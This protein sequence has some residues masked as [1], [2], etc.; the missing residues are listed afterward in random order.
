MNV[1]N[2]MLVEDDTFFAETFM[3]RLK[4]FGDYQIHHF[5]SVER[6]LANLTAVDPEIVFLDHILGGVN[7]VDALPIFKERK[8]GCEIV[9][10]SS[11]RDVKVLAKALQD[12]ASKYF[13]KDA[14]LMHNAGDVIQEVE[15]RPTGFRAFW[16]NFIADFKLLSL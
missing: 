16:Q 4:K 10:V 5:T 13:M 8:P 14:L 3:K 11:Q 9:V 6:A 2:I 1:N 12:G 15:A 7:G